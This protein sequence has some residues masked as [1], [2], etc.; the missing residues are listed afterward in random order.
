MGTTGYDRRHA[1]R[2]YTGQVVT[3]VNAEVFRQPVFNYTA[4]FDLLWEELRI[5]L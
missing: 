1:A 2:Q 3:V 5:P 4:N